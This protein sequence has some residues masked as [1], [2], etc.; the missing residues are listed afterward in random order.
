MNSQ[1]FVEGLRRHVSEAAVEDVIANL[2]RPP[3]RRV[4][5]QERA[6]SDWYNS[7]SAEDSTQVN[8]VIRSAVHEAVF[9][10]LAVLDGARTIDTKG[11]CFELTYVGDGRILLNDPRAVGLHDLLNAR[12]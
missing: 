12:A 4:A 5:V 3:A 9:G 1:D 2:K 8:D 6:R 10:L 7:L 11:G